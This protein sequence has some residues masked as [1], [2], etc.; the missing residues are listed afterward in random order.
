VDAFMVPQVTVRETFGTNATLRVQR[1]DPLVSAAEDTDDVDV[2]GD[3]AGRHLRGSSMLFAGRLLAVL[4]SMVTQ[5]V[6]VRS[7]S[8]AGYGTV[9]YVL[10]TGEFVRTVVSLGENQSLGR[11]LA[12]YEH[13]DR[14][15]RFVGTLV[16]V[17][18][19][20]L[21]STVVLVVAAAALWPVLGDRVVKDGSV[22]AVIA[23]AFLLAPIEAIDRVIEAAYAV[24][25][26]AGAIF[27]RKY[28]LAPGLRLAVV[29]AVGATGAGP[30][31][32]L[33][34]YIAA[35]ALGVALYAGGLVRILRGRQLLR[36][37][38]LEFPARQ[39]FGFSLPLLTTDL[40]PLC[41]NFLAVV[42]LGAV[43][44]TDEVARL[45]AILPAARLNQI[46]IFSFTLLFTPM[47]TRFFSRGDI[48]GMQ[49]VYWQTAV[50]L[51]V[52]SFPVLAIT[53][54]LAG[55]TTVALFGERYRSAAPVLAILAVG[56]YANAAFG[57]NSLTLQAFGHVRFLVR[58]NLA[59][60]VLDVVL[61]VALAP[62]F[63]AVGVAI[64]NATTLLA[65]NVA[66]QVGLRR[67]IGVE[68]VAPRALRVYATIVV[69][70]L[71][72]A[73]MQLVVHPPVVL[74]FA[75][76]ALVSA[77]VLALNRRHLDLVSTFPELRK[78][79]V[80]GRLLQQ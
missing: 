22:G 31:T 57:F 48:G 24:F 63:G 73:A 38:G 37:E 70:A 69:A 54:P 17:L 25:A 64:A 34:G 1:R 77:A 68:V 36:R 62:R 27:L 60:A 40:V 65:Q 50:W 32:L 45:R 74:A 33:L 71:A 19:K 4:L 61:L 16:M 47:A 80:L 39:Y 5:V 42:L 14:A 67:L 26:R 43:R 13:E 11:F 44:G 72:L 46:V 6:L 21:A 79:P 66:N 9:A 29:L 59:A 12:L 41:M 76:A 78:V 2:A 8:R 28:V 55:P 10:A 18:G 7:L 49:R 56:Y 53:A 58:V 52:L 30:R 20:V 3:E 15:G 35:S 23:L 51:T 75:A